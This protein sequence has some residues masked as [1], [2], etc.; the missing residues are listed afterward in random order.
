M[1]TTQERG[2]GL[3][4]RNRQMRG[5]GTTV[6]K[7]KGH[8]AVLH[9]IQSQER[10][11]TVMLQSGETMIGNLVGRDRFTMT[12]RPTQ[13]LNKGRRVVIFKHAV[14]SFFADEAPKTSDE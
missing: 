12:I 3:E 2:H 11:V 7:H 13:G 14:E 9:A 5:N 4:E 10:I 8:D 1:S 6:P